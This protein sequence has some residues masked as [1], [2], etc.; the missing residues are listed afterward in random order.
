MMKTYTVLYAEDVPHYGVHEIQAV[1]DAAAIEAAI[2][3]H[4]RGDATLDDPVWNS[5]VC[6][7]IVHIEDPDGNIIDEDRALDDYFI[8]RNGDAA[9]ILCDAAPQM[10]AALKKAKDLL[11]EIYPYEDR[12]AEH[13]ELIVEINEALAAAELQV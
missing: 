9:R 10:L 4:E 6:A 3:F 12:S 1:T 7:R 5:S 11:D 8:R 13:G 2:A